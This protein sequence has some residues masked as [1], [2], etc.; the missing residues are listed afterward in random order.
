[1]I[2]HKLSKKGQSMYDLKITI[3]NLKTAVDYLVKN[4]ESEI[5]TINSMDREGESGLA[6]SYTDINKKSAIV[7]IHENNIGPEVQRIEKIYSKE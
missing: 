2:G 1:M 5:A 4:S 7:R 6:I 3:K